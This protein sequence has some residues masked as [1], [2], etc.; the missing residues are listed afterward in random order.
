MEWQRQPVLPGAVM[1]PAPWSRG[2]VLRVGKAGLR[3]LSACGLRLVWLGVFAAGAA[4]SSSSFAC[5]APPGGPPPPCSSAGNPIDVTTGNKFQREVDLAPVPGTLGV[6]VVRYYNSTD[7]AGGPTGFGWRLSYEARLYEVSNTLQ[8]SLADGSRRMFDRDPRHP[9]SCGGHRPE[10]GRIVIDRTAGDRERFRWEM[11]DGDRFTFDE[12]GF[13]SQI[14]RTGGEQ[15]ILARGPQGELLRVSDSHGGVLEFVYGSRKAKGF[16]GLA[17]ILAPSGRIRY[18]H[19]D[20]PAASGR[21]NLTAVILPDGSGRHY[22]YEKELQ[23]ADLYPHAL[24]GISAI[25]VSGHAQRIETWS[26]DAQG[27]AV[28]FERGPFGKG[29]HRITLR[30]ERPAA[31]GGL[32]EEHLG[33]TVLT[34]SQGRVTRYRHAIVADEHRLVEALGPGCE[35]CEASNRRFRY[36]GRGQFEEVEEL[37]GDTRPQTVGLRR[38]LHDAAGRL[39]EIQQRSA[40]GGGTVRSLARYRYEGESL[41]PTRIDR[42]SVVPG[43]EATVQLAYDGN[44]HLVRWEERGFAPAGRERGPAA[45]SAIARGGSARYDPSGR[46]VH[47]EAAGFGGPGVVDWTYDALGFVQAAR[48]PGGTLEVVERGAAHVPA[49]IEWRRGTRVVRFPAPSFAGSAESGAIEAWLVDPKT[50]A[51][52][53][54]TMVSVP[55]SGAPTGVK[56]LLLAL[57]PNAVLATSI[58]VPFRS[59]P[60]SAGTGNPDESAN[61][62]AV[63]TG[64]DGAAGTAEEG[65]LLSVAAGGRTAERRF[66]DFGRLAAYREPDEGWHEAEYDTQGRI[67][68]IVDPRGVTTRFTYGVDPYPL[69]ALRFLQGSTAPVQTVSYRYENGLL[70]EESVRDA[71]GL[72]TLATQRDALGRVM[73][74]MQS[75][76]GLGGTPVRWGARYAYDALGRRTALELEGLSSVHFRYDDRGR[77]IGI[78]ASRFVGE[79][80][81]VRSVSWTHLD[82]GYEVASSVSLGD[83]T[84][85]ET[86]WSAAEKSLARSET[87]SAGAGDAARLPA[88]S[89]PGTGHDA[90]GLPAAVGTRVGALDLEWDAARQLRRVSRAGTVVA[91]YLYDARGRRIAKIVGEGAQRRVEVFAYD[92]A[93]RIG[94]ARVGSDGGLAGREETVYLGLRPVALLRQRTGGIGDSLAT[95]VLG[96]EPRFLHTDIRGAVLA[97]TDAG[98]SV[99]WQARV[100]AFGRRTVLHNAETAFQPLLLVGQHV[101]EESGLVYNG[102]RYYLAESGVFLS[103]DPAGLSQSL[104]G[105]PSSLLLNQYAFAAGNPWLNVDPD[106]AATLTYFAIDSGSP[107]AAGKQP[108]SARWAFILSNIAG[109]PGVVFIYDRGGSFL[110][111]G[112]A[113]QQFGGTGP[114]GPGSGSVMNDF[115][116][117]YQNLS[118]FYMFITTMDDTAAANLIKYL[119]QPPSCG[120]PSLPPM[121]AVDMGLQGTLDPTKA[122]RLVNCPGGA[123]DAQKEAYRILA[124]IEAWESTDNNCANAT[125]HNLYCAANAWTPALNPMTGL[126]QQASYG[127]AQF[128]VNDLLSQL[129]G[130]SAVQTQLGITSQQVSTALSKSNKTNTWWV[131]LKGL[132][133]N[134]LDAKAL[135][136]AWAQNGAAFQKD[137]GLGQADFNRMLEWAQLLRDINQVNS[138]PYLVAICPVKT[139]TAIKNKDLVDPDCLRAKLGSTTLLPGETKAQ[140]T[141]RLAT[142]AEMSSLASLLGTSLGSTALNLYIRNP[143]NDGEAVQG[144]MG[145]AIFQDPA[146]GKAL[147][148]IYQTKSLFDQL[149][150]GRINQIIAAIGSA[151]PTTPAAELL[152]AQQVFFKWNHG[153]NK[154]GFTTTDGYVQSVTPFFQ[155]TFCDSGFNTTNTLLPSPLTVTK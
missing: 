35:E 50:G 144:F 101:D 105:V 9:A 33:L 54:D 129:Q 1:A 117:H 155:V 46:L 26:Y 128:T 95:R 99:T 89:R 92:G 146:L 75:I 43:R 65:L 56:D 55:G 58:P 72:R 53:A 77:V 34:D 108:N 45:F 36:D 93:R 112:A 148:K 59:P 111:N 120:G 68:R 135:Q 52:V 69:E 104:T 40:T 10:D 67:A 106:G 98:G 62:A 151:T 44:G 84:T 94:S 51:P 119:T 42:P 100:D 23:G 66:D 114:F 85:V 71:D 47:L 121:P 102:A 31:A 61:G 132:G 127:W 147:L 27:R 14:E 79:L 80:E 130:N 12:D 110:A 113:Y 116:T 81:L 91:T 57:R 70:V 19:D 4:Y 154:K 28:T 126:P 125:G 29:P 32:D 150:I 138:T 7:R 90:A 5:S 86:D 118:G 30:F 16:G 6:E 136:G 97:M 143:R 73:A 8:I 64:E 134:A 18:E 74:E 87:V 22:H 123:T 141:A 137:T 142:F 152:L 37:S 48:F 88:F 39:V 63:L 109:M 3:S 133:V 13:L 15:V 20:E 60:A 78:G 17:A 11:P 145:S 82:S 139:A 153:I 115:A 21:G 2:P 149:A 24:T 25:D 49:R 83:G 124:A 107:T 131:T 41:L 103:P 122:S 76:E 140:M 96:D 38:Y